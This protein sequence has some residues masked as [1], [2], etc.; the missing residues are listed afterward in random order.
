MPPTSRQPGSEPD[1]LPRLLGVGLVLVLAEAAVLVVVAVTLLA[2]W[3][4][5]GW[6]V[7]PVELFLMLFTL[8]VAAMLVA[9]VRALYARRRAGRAPVV[10]WQLLQGATAVT[11]L[12]ADP[13]V[14]WGALA[15]LMM[16]TVVVAGLMSRAGVE[17]TTRLARSRPAPP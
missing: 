8:A 9:A 4:A 5:S 3:A 15:A 10:T 6:Q 12:P 13:P 11:L 16:A 7:I 14:R 1:R 2:R 17:Y